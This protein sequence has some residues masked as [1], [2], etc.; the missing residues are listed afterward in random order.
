MV[1]WC[2]TFAVE[3]DT[4]QLRGQRLVTMSATNRV[5]NR[6]ASLPVCFAA[7]FCL[8]SSASASSSAVG[9]AQQ[10]DG[11]VSGHV[12]RADTGAPFVG[13]V[14]TLYPCYL[15]GVSWFLRTTTGADGSYTVSGSPFC[16]TATASAPGFYPESY[17]SDIH[18]WVNLSS[19][20]KVENIDFHLAVA[21]VIWGSVSYG[22][23]PVA[24]IRVSAI[25]RQYEVGGESHPQTVQFVMTDEKGNFRLD[26][27]PEGDY[28]VCVDA[29]HETDGATG[30]S[31]GWKYHRSCYPS[32]PSTEKAQQV[33]ASTGKETTGIRFQ[34]TAD[35]TFTIVAEVQGLDTG[36]A[37][38]LY[39]LY[40]V[41]LS[42]AGLSTYEVRGNFVTI[43]QIFPGNYTLTIL[44]KDNANNHELGRGSQTLQVVDS[45]VHVTVPTGKLDEVRGPAPVQ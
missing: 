7:T 36:A 24:N 12:Y 11:T 40:L 15:A 29:A 10:V 33:H 34:M 30:P 23:Q 14:V 35:K 37:R 1:R 16:Y 42:P 26:A 17:G 20:T 41:A 39:L 25:G 27:L 32:A 21:G 3:S 4:I 5:R 19:G 38:R 31:S 43:P 13:A 44:V 28:F 22:N 8:L 45:D 2:A 9:G 18:P 6:V